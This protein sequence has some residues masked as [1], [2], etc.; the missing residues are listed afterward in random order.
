M[1][2]TATGFYNPRAEYAAGRGEDERRRRG[3][4]TVETAGMN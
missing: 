1:P 3:E 2:R 4:A